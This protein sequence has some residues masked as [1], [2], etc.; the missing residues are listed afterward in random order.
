MN[1]LAALRCSIMR[2]PS[3]RHGK[4]QHSYLAG[5]TSLVDAMYA[6]IG[7]CGEGFSSAEQILLQVA[8]EAVATQFA[9]QSR[10]YDLAEVVRQAHEVA[11]NY[12]KRYALPL[13]ESTTDVDGERA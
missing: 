8:A 10:A 4:K 2:P 11:I 1:E 13:V 7:D 3:S 6:A 5:H 12:R 9:T